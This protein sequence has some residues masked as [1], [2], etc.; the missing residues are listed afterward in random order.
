MEEHQRGARRRHLVQTRW[1]EVAELR[2]SVEVLLGLIYGRVGL[3]RHT[4]T[5]DETRSRKRDTT[6]DLVRR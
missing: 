3:E 2:M 4:D 6:R 1:K 5:H